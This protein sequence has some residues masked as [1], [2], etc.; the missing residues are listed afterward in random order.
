MKDILKRNSPVF[1]IGLITFIVFLII[2]ATSQ[3]RNPIEPTLIQ[4]QE[5][6]LVTQH[7]NMIGSKE[8][9]VLVTAFYDLTHSSSS[10]YHTASKELLNTYPSYVSFAVRHFPSDKSEDAF[11]AAKAAQAAGN[12]SGFWEFIEL[13]FQNKGKYQEGDFVRY[14]DIL[15]FDLRQFRDDFRDD[16]IA[17]QINQDMGYGKSLGVTETPTFFLNGRQMVVTSPANF[18]TQIEEALTRYGV[19]I[20]KVEKE[21]QT[22]EQE[23]IE[24]TYSDFY[25][26]VDQRFGTKE[27]EFVDNNFDPRNS[28]ATAGQLVRFTNNSENTIVL[29]QIMKKYE[30][31]SDDVTIK[32]GESFEFR[33]ELRKQGLWTYRNVGNS[34]RASIMVSELPE[35]LMQ[36]LPE[37]D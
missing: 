12:Q 30:A 33:F 16:G 7:T 6:E 11:N 28:S 9:P 13:V 32:P 4:T 25:D 8:A 1:F 22:R 5:D 35:D 14:A 18:K 21:M 26:I 36:L 34:N 17:W 15:N 37:E 2:I 10:K 24:Q 29:T 31:L 3:L 23:I 27:I 20:E 19:D